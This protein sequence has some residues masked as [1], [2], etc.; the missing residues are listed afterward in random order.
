MI[1][2]GKSRKLISLDDLA[3]RASRSEI[4]SIGTVVNKIMGIIRDPSSSAV[5]LK[6]MIEI[7]PPL[8]AK[9]LRRA[10]SAIYGLKREIKS[11]RE[12]IVLIGF[13]TV[14]ELCLSLKIAKF[15]S[16]EKASANYSRKK[17]WK[18]SL[19]VA[20]CG[21][22]LC[23]REFRQEGDDI[24]SA[25]LLHDLGIIVEEQFL[26]EAFEEIA[27]ISAEQGLSI[28]AAERQV[29]GFT[30]ADIGQKL[31]SAWR[32][33]EELAMAIGRHHQP[34]PCPEPFARTTMIISVS[35]YA[36][37][38]AGITCGEVPEDSGNDYSRCLDALKLSPEAL[39]VIVEDVA[40][41]L[42]EL[43]RSGDLYL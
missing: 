22:Y 25:G 35:D 11:I 14:R 13:N 43:E 40:A 10:N 23:R 41:E 9:V 24:Y 38:K 17:L 18:H 26:P 3:T 33:P 7:D 29:L 31:V 20:L 39:E 34:F 32:I 4:S 42:E 37:R 15:F 5:Q 1:R 8:S 16:D 27:R 36:C 12:A 19:A 2:Q 28:V 30:H 21:K 6:E